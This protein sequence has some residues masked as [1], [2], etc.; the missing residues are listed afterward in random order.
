LHTLVTGETVDSQHT[1]HVHTKR[2]NSGGIVATPQ[3]FGRLDGVTR[4][5]THGPKSP[6][7]TLVVFIWLS[8]RLN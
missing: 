1:W 5:V 8:H 6:G 3:G 2:A 7:V 4:F